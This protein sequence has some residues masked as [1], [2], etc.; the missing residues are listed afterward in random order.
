M[1]SELQRIGPGA[2]TLATAMANVPA[3]GGEIELT[4]GIYDVSNVTVPAKTMLTRKGGPITIRVAAGTTGLILSDDCILN[5]G[6]EFTAR[7]PAAVKTIGIRVAGKRT[8]LYAPTFRTFGNKVTATTPLSL[9]DAP[10]ALVY[11]SV[12]TAEDIWADWNHLYSPHFEFCYGGLLL[13]SVSNAM[14]SNF[15]ARGEIGLGGA[16][17]SHM[18]G[19]P[20]GCPVRINGIWTAHCKGPAL[21]FTKDADITRDGGSIISNW[22]NE[23]GP[24]TAIAAAQ[25][26]SNGNVFT[27]GIS[28]V[29]GAKGFVWGPTAKGNVV[30]GVVKRT[31]Q[32]NVGPPVD[33]G[34]V[35][36]QSYVT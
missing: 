10:Y 28:F 1:A 34:P 23:P 9:A 22:T 20:A 17:R 15:V 2:S 29:G 31:G 3:T 24:H 12:G 19:N 5:A 18:T 33:S 11:D 27:G 36:A 13:V 8:K 25:V 16:V 21:Q 35:S 7:D 14:V 26:D 30:E 4:G 32:N 6:F